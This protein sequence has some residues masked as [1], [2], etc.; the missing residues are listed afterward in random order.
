MVTYVQLFY[1]ML[2]EWVMAAHFFVCAQALSAVFN[3]LVRSCA[4][5]LFLE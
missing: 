1:W 5:L 4:Q 2:G 3:Q